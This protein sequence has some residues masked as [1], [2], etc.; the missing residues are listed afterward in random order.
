MRKQKWSHL[1]QGAVTTYIFMAMDETIGSEHILE[2]GTAMYARIIKQQKTAQIKR[3]S[4]FIGAPRGLKHG[5]HRAM[6]DGDK[7]SSCAYIPENAGG[8]TTLTDVVSAAKAYH[9]F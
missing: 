8:W 1:S 9:R 5:E 6:I 4:K 3:R 7:S 2:G